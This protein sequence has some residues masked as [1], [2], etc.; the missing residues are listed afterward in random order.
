MPKTPLLSIGLFVSLL[1]FSMGGIL[2]MGCSI[3]NSNSDPTPRPTRTK[4]PSNDGQAM[5]G[6]SGGNNAPTPQPQATTTDDDTISREITPGVKF[7]PSQIPVGMSRVVG[8]VTNAKDDPIAGAAV[9]VPDGTSP[10]PERA[11][12]TNANGE[13]SWGLPPGTFILQVNA[14][15][16]QPARAEVKTEPDKQVVQDFKL[17]KMP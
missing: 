5:P 15:G 16:Y 10:V 4:I 8:R 12:L 14:A 6:S 17:E 3:I 9:T 11:A 2:L 13:Y 1:A 7:N